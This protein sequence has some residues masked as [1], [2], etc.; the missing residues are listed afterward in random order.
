MFVGLI[1]V[2]IIISAMIMFGF[3]KTPSGYHPSWAPDGCR[4]IT[5]PQYGPRVIIRVSDME[6]FDT[7]AKCAQVILDALTY[8]DE[9]FR[10]RAGG[11]PGIPRVVELQLPGYGSFREEFYI[12][13]YEVRTNDF[14]F[15]VLRVIRGP[16]QYF[17][18]E[19]TLPQLRQV[20]NGE[21][22]LGFLQ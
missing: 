15:N 6:N 21:L 22:T 20:A 3:Y 10:N 9:F 11:R 19:I 16:T 8:E 14:D 2:A 1:V 4:V 17:N 7:E 12:Q 18:D 5:D 13:Y